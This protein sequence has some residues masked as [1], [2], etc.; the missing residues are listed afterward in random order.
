MKKHENAAKENAKLVSS[1]ISQSESYLVE[2]HAQ[3]KYKK[4]ELYQTYLIFQ[5]NDI[6]EA[7]R[8]KTLEIRVPTYTK[9]IEFKKWETKFSAAQKKKYLQY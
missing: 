8:P 1:L 7:D 9:T 5:L 2:K 3:Y 6:P 4:L